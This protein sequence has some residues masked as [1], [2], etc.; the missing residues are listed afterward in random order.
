[1][2]GKNMGENLAVVPLTNNR[3][4]G[5]GYDAA[6]NMTSDGGHSY[7]F[8][9][10]NRIR[11]VAGV[12]YT[13]DGDGERAAKSTGTLYWQGGGKDALA[14][15]TA[16]GTL[17][18]EYVFF[19][20]KRAA[21]VDIGSPETVHYYISDHLGSTTVMANADGS[22]KQGE[23][24]YYPYGPEIV[25]IA[26]ST[27]NHYKFTGKER[28]TESGLDYFFARYYSQSLGR[29]MTPD[30]SATPVLVPYATLG[31]PQTLNLY[32]YV[33]NNPITG[34]DPD[35]H[36]CVTHPSKSGGGT[37]VNNPATGVTDSGQEGGWHGY[38]A[39]GDDA[40][41]DGWT[42]N[43]GIGQ[44]AEGEAAANANPA[45]LV[46]IGAH[47]D[48]RGCEISYELQH[49]TPGYEIVQHDPGRAS[50][51]KYGENTSFERGRSFLD[52]ISIGWNSST[53][54][55]TGIQTFYIAVPGPH[56][57][58]GR[59]QPVLV[60]D[61][62][63]HDFYKLAVWIRAQSPGSPGMILVNGRNPESRSWWPP[64]D[65]K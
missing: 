59:L 21:R 30:W 40:S 20:G 51:T 28:D 5:F 15:G 33:E 10:E 53:K 56:G 55:R 18:Y 26:D 64:T 2:A 46:V 62:A 43:G 13:Y 35:G 24:D 25:I 42:P 50:T 4:S 3:L 1:M 38:D 65:N 9:A 48:A 11:T 61:K 32:S 54:G 47:C 16:S 6:G 36:F 49:A 29:F 34:T 14:E 57:E 44:S 7:S 22:Q 31:N 17:T 23:S 27:G 60:Q 41:A 12:T 37:C 58:A 45:R 52:G 39:V 8:D 63:G 19:N